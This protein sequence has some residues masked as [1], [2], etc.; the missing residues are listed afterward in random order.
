M[1]VPLTEVL[2]EVINTVKVQKSMKSIAKIVHLSSV[3]QSD[4][5]E[6]TRILF[7][8]KENTNNDYI[9]QF[10]SCC[11]RSAI[12]KNI[13]WMHIAY[14]LLCQPCHKDTFSTQLIL[15]KTVYPCGAAM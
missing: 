14:A 12:L 9:Q 5:Y 1:T 3:V 7:V 8:R 15:M 10:I 4:C 13:R 6:A 2:T 11:H